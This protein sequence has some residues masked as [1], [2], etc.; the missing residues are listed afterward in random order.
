M[1]PR[2]LRD[3][4]GLERERA[5]RSGY[6]LDQAEGSSNLI[7]PSGTG[8]G[9]LCDPGERGHDESGTHQGGRRLGSSGV[10]PLVWWDVRGR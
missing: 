9:S 2:D 8:R 7:G 1:V 4:R 5:S 3:T 10:R 6:Y